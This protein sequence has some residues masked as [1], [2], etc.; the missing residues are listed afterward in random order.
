MHLFFFF[1]AIHV[2]LEQTV[3]VFET[4]ETED[5]LKITSLDLQPG[6]G[7]PGYLAN[8]QKHT[9]GRQHQTFF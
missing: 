6:C 5:S 9:W 3:G 8:L 1:P 7:L 4:R 2:P